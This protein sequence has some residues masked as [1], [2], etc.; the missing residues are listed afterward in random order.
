LLGN[1]GDFILLFPFDGKGPV[2][3]NNM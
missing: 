3:A 1:L 2:D